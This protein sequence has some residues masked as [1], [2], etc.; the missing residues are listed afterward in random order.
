MKKQIG[1]LAKN[2]TSLSWPRLLRFPI[3]RLV[4]LAVAGTQSGSVLVC[5]WPL[6]SNIGYKRHKS[7]QPETQQS[8]VA[9]RTTHGNA[10]FFYPLQPMFEEQ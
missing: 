4:T 7:W 10:Q 5:F 9:R 3:S 1:G 2:S 8:Y 6:S